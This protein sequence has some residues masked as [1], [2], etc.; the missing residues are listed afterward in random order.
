MTVIACIC[1]LKWCNFNG[2]NCLILAPCWGQAESAYTSVHAEE[3]HPAVN[4]TIWSLKGPALWQWNIYSGE[5]TVLH[6]SS[7]SFVGSVMSFCYIFET[8]HLW[9]QNNNSCCIFRPFMTSHIKTLLKSFPIAQIESK[10]WP[11]PQKGK[12][13]WYCSFKLLQFL[14]SLLA[15]LKSALSSQKWKI[16]QVEIFRDLTKGSFDRLDYNK[17]FHRD[18]LGKCTN[19]KTL[20]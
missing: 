5:E 8:I 15:I 18:S 14:H 16:R 2:L 10:P 4:I 13:S 6:Q 19:N 12:N 1:I 11:N 20:Y 3:G 9:Y 7:T 17:V